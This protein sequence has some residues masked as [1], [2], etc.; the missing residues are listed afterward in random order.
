MNKRTYLTTTLP[1]V[2]GAPHIGHAIEFALADVI[3]RYKRSK[4]GRENVFFN[5]GTDEH[6]LK[7]FTKA[8]ENGLDVKDYVDEY[9]TKWEKFCKT[10]LVS[11]DNFYR[12]SDES[13]IKVAQ[14]FWKRCEENGDIYK[15]KYEGL[16]CVGCE[17]FKT[18][19]DLVNGKCPLHD[20]EPI[21]FSEE[22]Y[23]FKLSKYTKKV[24]DNATID[25][26]NHNAKKVEE[27]KNFI[28]SGTNSE[29]EDI[30]ISRLKKNLPWGVPVP[31]DETQ[32]MYVWFDALSNYVGAVGFPG[33]EKKLDA[34][35]ENTDVETIQLCGPDN[36][37]FQG[38][39]WQ[40]MLASAGLSFTK[41]LLVHGTVL[42]SD[43]TKMSKTKGN[44]I[45]PIDQINKYGAEALRYYL[46][47]G[48]PTYSDASFIESDLVNSF[49]AD[50]A[51]NYGNLLNRVIHLSN[52]KG[53]DLNDE[54]YVSTEFRNELT[55]KL[56]IYQ[57]F[58][59]KYDVYGAYGVIREVAAWGNRY[60]TE[61]EPWNK[62]V[63]LEKAS[64]VLQNLGLLLREVTKAYEFTLP[65]SA[66]RAKESLEKKEKVILFEKII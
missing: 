10:F 50:L 40:G 18:E 7:I 16:Y 24:L 9:A 64:E 12:T 5:V 41:K 52:L 55:E 57:D 38:A 13:H 25:F 23:Y 3:V 58:W 11:Y 31:N 48:I 19:K 54:Q 14:T 49:N 28:Q 32:V 22:N 36:L 27:L 17:E 45:D 34:W 26:L 63:G 37:R 43:G 53:I 44:V 21:K 35:W 47:T 1:Y 56:K 66:K 51:N 29:L 33:D 39:I 59:D 2:N 30:S 62:N 42:A 61:E 4:E 46:V 15:K 8:K 60:I 20:R 6:G 65:E